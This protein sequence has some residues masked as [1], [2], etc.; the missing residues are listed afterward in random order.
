MKLTADLIYNKL[1][2]ANEAVSRALGLALDKGAADISASAARNAVDQGIFDT[3][4]LVGSIGWD[5]APESTEDNPVRQVFVGA[6]YAAV[7]EFGGHGNPARPYMYP[8]YLE[9][10]DVISDAI[11]GLITGELG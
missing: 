1:P 5:E 7:H 2:E 3:G 10:R 11:G 4:N 8:A 9:H 6:E